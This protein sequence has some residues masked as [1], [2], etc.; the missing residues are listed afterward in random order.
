MIG[1]SLLMIVVAYIYIAR[2]IIKKIGNKK[3]KYVILAVFILIPTWDVILGNLTFRYLCYKE[4]GEKIFKTAENVPG[5]LDL[6]AGDPTNTILNYG[7]KHL[8]TKSKMGGYKYFSMSHDGTIVTSD[9][10]EPVSNYS[11]YEKKH[12]Y[13]FPWRI[14]RYDQIIEHIDKKEIM[15]VRKRLSYSGGWISR[16]LG[17]IGGGT[18]T[19]PKIKMG[20]KEFFINT[21]RPKNN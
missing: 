7:Y 19:C 8:E 15:A 1:L 9:I 10:D 4:G 12:E 17:E 13:N 21:L 18:L 6:Y 20:Y 5:F 14:I 11:F 2:F 3:I 16:S